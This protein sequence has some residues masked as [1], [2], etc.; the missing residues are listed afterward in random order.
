[1]RPAAQTATPMTMTANKKIVQLCFKMN[2]FLCYLLNSRD[3]EAFLTNAVIDNKRPT[4]Q[5]HQSD[6]ICSMPSFEGFSPKDSLQPIQST[7][8]KMR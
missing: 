8:K 4:R 1:M 5:L 3:I 2:R 7:N 6:N